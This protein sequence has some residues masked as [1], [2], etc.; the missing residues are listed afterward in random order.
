MG[1]YFLLFLIGGAIG[2]VAVF[3]FVAGLSTVLGR[4][5]IV[6]GIIVAA[7]LATYVIIRW[8][9]VGPVM[10]VERRFAIKALR[11]GGEL[12]TG[13]W[14]H[15]LGLFVV[16]G[17]IVGIPGGVLNLVWSGIPFLGRVL[18]GLTL[19]VVSAY[20]ATAIVVYYFDRRCRIEDF[21]IHHLA[22]QIGQS[23]TAPGA[24]RVG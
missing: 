7:I 21:D 17:L 16:V 14:W 4:A 9:L 20:S 8:S 19:S 1:T 23:A 11:R 5:A 15:T 6:L 18:N 12:V 2:G 3:G 24:S 10:I 13:A 22:A